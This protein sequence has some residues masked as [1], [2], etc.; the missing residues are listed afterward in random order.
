MTTRTLRTIA[1]Q[2]QRDAIRI[3]DAVTEMIALGGMYSREVAQ[4]AADEIGRPTYATDDTEEV[5]AAIV[6]WL[7]SQE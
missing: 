2:R 6:K 3:V 7:R 4:L 1:T 5:I